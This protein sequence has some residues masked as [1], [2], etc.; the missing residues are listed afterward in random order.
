MVVCILCNFDDL[1]PSFCFFLVI[2]KLKYKKNYYYIC[3][4][5]FS[6][7]YMYVFPYIGI[8]IYIHIYISYILSYLG[9]L[10]FSC[11]L[12]RVQWLSVNKYSV[13]DWN[14]HHCNFRISWRDK[15]RYICMYIY[16]AYNSLISYVT[17]LN[18]I[19]SK[20]YVYDCLSF[21]I[22]VIKWYSKCSFSRGKICYLSRWYKHRF[23][24]YA[25]LTPFSHPLTL[26]LIHHQVPL[27]VLSFFDPDI[28]SFCLSFSR[29]LSSFVCF[30]FF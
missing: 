19:P 13:N 12:L 10:K 1:F 27:Y 20:I 22:E 29:F 25:T 9:L 11:I 30:F 16:R 6:I 17:V 14:I 7:L 21:T 18:Q 2:V 15:N 23:K 8:Y 26:S 4:I 3:Y 5:V 28:T 24:S